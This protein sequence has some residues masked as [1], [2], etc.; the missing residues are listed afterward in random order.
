MTTTTDIKL[1]AIGLME[2]LAQTKREHQTRHH[3]VDLCTYDHA[4]EV[5]FDRAMREASADSD[6]VEAVGH[7]LL[8]WLF[9]LHEEHPEEVLY[10]LTELLG[11][12]LGES[13]R[14]SQP[15]LHWGEDGDP[16]PGECWSCV[17]EHLGNLR[18]KHLRGEERS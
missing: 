17:M 5:M 1:L 14:Q 6:E 3:Q 15:C 4:P 8:E 9:D 11:P 10:D 16:H 12:Q 7:A 2:R 13:A 18:A